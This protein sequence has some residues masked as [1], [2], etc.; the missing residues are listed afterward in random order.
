MTS[1]LWLRRL[2]PDARRRQPME[3]TSGGRQA[4]M[5]ARSTRRDCP[6]LQSGADRLDAV[7]W[8]FFPCNR[9]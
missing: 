7:A 4:A 5:D 2:F 6:C 9:L 8:Q 3:E 1:P